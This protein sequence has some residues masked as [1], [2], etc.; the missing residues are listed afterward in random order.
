MLIGANLYVLF[1]LLKPQI[2]LITLF[3]NERILFYW[4]FLICRMIVITLGV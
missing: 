4:N 2:L 1:I 3:E